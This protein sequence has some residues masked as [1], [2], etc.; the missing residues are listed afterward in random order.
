MK[1]KIT[2]QR[3]RKD[4]MIPRF[5]AK[6]MMTKYDDSTPSTKIVMVDAM[7][8]IGLTLTVPVPQVP[9]KQPEISVSL[10]LNTAT[11]IETSAPAL[12]NPVKVCCNLSGT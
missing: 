6:Q 3:F 1:Q 9:V 2:E 11:S 10:S 4:A 5:L 8:E 12:S 7:E